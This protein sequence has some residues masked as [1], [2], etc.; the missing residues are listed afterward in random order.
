MNSNEG[1]QD[2][3]KLTLASMVTRSHSDSSTSNCKVYNIDHGIDRLVVNFCQNAPTETKSKLPGNSC[4]ESDSSNKTSCRWFGCNNSFESTEELRD[5]LQ[6]IHID[7]HDVEAKY[8]CLWQGCKVYN[9]PSV[10]R[11][12]LVQHVCKHTGDRLIKCLIDGCNM[13]FATQ[14]GLARHVPSHFSNKHQSGSK[15][16]NTNDQ[17]LSQI[18]NHQT[19]SM[20]KANHDLSYGLTSG[21]RNRL[22]R[23]RLHA[24]GVP[25]SSPVQMSDDPFDDK[26]MQVLKQRIYHAAENV[27]LM[28]TNKITF[29]SQVIARRYLEGDS[30]VACGTRCQLLLRWWPTNMLEDE[31]IHESDL[32]KYETISISTRNLPLNGR[33]RFG[34]FY[35]KFRSRKE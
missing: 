31:W 28:L 6:K 2:V 9:K 29:R 19:T 7:T 3:T 5:H 22:K 13:T 15:K 11:N 26:V 14:N 32:Q 21:H 35:C 20:T 17:A 4:S 10:S 30:A 16:S 18:T 12:W 34:D 23:R 24:L 33:L 25:Q 8:A 27:G 1:V